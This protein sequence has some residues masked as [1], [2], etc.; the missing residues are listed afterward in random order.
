[1]DT[2][3]KTL[4]KF[5]TSVLADRK[6]EKSGSTI[7]ADRSRR[8]DLFSF[9]TSASED[10]GRTAMSDA[11]IVRDKAVLMRYSDSLCCIQIS[12]TFLMLLAGHGK[13]VMYQHLSLADE[14]HQRRPH[15]PLTLL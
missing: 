13:L 15:T 9:M 1:M 12:N 11:E 8:H 4:E 2:A 5:M 7:E 3:Y 14:T 10:D 6:A